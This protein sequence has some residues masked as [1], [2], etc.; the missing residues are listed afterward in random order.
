MYCSFKEVEL[1]KKVFDECVFKNVVCWTSLISGL[2]GNG[3]VEDARKVFGG[4]CER[5][6]VSYSAMVSG[7]VRNGCYNEAIELFREMG[8]DGRVKANRAVLMSVLS[9]CGAVGAFDV[10]RRIHS[11]LVGDSFGF[12]VELGTALIDFYAKCGCIE[13]AEDVFSRMDCKDVATWSAMILGLA[14]N[15]KNEMA[16]EL[17]EEMEQ[18]GP[19]PNDITFVAVLVA[20]N[21][22]TLVKE[23]WRLLG[24]MSKVYGIRPSIEHYGC[25]VDLLTRSG[26]LKG[27]EILIRL[28][29]MEPDGAIWGSFLQ[30]CL[31]HG[32]IDLAESAGKHL[33]ELEP[34]HSGRYVLLANMYANMG[35]W[36]G[37][38]NLRNMMK[39]RKVDTA[40]G[41]SFIEVDGIVHKFLVSDQCHPQVKDL[42]EILQVLNKFMN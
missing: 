14:T 12:D 40:P 17:F 37:V 27:A 42:H 26:Q 24:R 21:H 30:G 38:I 6:D 8:M 41:W 28:M 7:F 31:T 10:G 35:S 11:E 13:L 32:E 3:C 39:K 9:A 22:K 4:M 18:K 16:I 5:N 34:Q 33:L 25:M 1:G 2:F 36:E 20:C 15:G 19:V 23:A 29:P